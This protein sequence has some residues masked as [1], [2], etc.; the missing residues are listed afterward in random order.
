MKVKG[1]RGELYFHVVNEDRR[2]G[3]GDN[4]L[5]VPG[6]EL[7]ARA[8]RNWDGNLRLEPVE[9]KHGMHG[10]K[11]INSY[12]MFRLCPRWWLCIVRLRCNVR[13]FGFK[14]AGMRREVVAMRQYNPKEGPPCGVKKFK[15]NT[16]A[17]NWVM[18]HPWG[19]PK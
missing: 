9:C 19:G 11:S 2:L 16:E 7:K 17:Y 12:E 3:H 4:R 13:R 5:V 1:V 15:N 8:S 10:C 14:S 18:E 6:K